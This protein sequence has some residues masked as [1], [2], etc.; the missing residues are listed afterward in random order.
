MD[1]PPPEDAKLAE[2]IAV[3][4]W[5]LDLPPGCECMG[6]F[7]VV[8]APPVNPITFVALQ[9]GQVSTSLTT[10]TLTFQLSNFGIE[11]SATSCEGARA[12]TYHIGRLGV[13]HTSYR[14]TPTCR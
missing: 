9:G 3:I 11:G 6:A 13:L 2:R 5:F 14:S 8:V 7:E 10:G 1:P 12:C 4:K